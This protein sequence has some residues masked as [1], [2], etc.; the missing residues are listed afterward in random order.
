MGEHA[1]CEGF[2]KVAQC[3]CYKQAKCQEASKD[4]DTVAEDEVCKGFRSMA[5]TNQSPVQAS[6]C[7]DKG[8]QALGK[9]DSGVA[10]GYMV[11]RGTTQ[12][13]S[14][15]GGAEVDA[16]DNMCGM[17]NMGDNGE[18][19]APTKGCAGEVGASDA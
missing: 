16:K 6:C 4:S 8:R 7:G 15:K 18:G 5:K 17:E 14:Q 1:L 11:G 10:M 13:S 12:P 2:Q 3:L 19:A 9:Q